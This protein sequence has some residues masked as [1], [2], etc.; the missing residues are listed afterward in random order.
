MVK[1]SNYDHREKGT[2]SRLWN[3]LEKLRGVPN[4]F[5]DKLLKRKY[6]I[7]LALP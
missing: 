4:T 2:D 7:I 6:V 3:E 5:K 1:S